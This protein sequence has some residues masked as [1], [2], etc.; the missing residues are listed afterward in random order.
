AAELAGYSEDGGR[1]IQQAVRI[2]LNGGLGTSMGLTGPKSLLPV[3]E[4][5]TF[6]EVIMRQAEVAGI[7]Q[8]LM[9][10][11][12]THTATLAALTEIP[13][14]TP[15]LTFI[16]NK[17]PKILQENL[18]PADWPEAPELEWNPPGHGDIYTAIQTSG[19][20]DRLLEGG[21]RYALICN[22]DN[23][24][25]TVDLPLLGF[26]AA[27]DIPFVMEVAR[28]T[29]ADAKGGH[30]AV[31][32]DGG[33]ILRESA[34][35]PADSD[36]GDIGRYA[37]FNT[38]NLWVNLPYLKTLIQQ[39]GTIPLPLILNP[40]T[41]DPRDPASPAV[42][43]LESAMGAATGLFEGARA[44]LVPRTRFFPV[45]KCND[46]LILRSDCFT[47]NNRFQL[48]ANPHQNHGGPL[49]SL[50]PAFYRR[51]DQFEARFP[52]GV[53]SLLECEQLTIRGDIRF[54]SPVT[55]KGKVGL[56]N[57]DS[58]QKTIEAGSVI[59]EDLIL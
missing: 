8:V 36:G 49:V 59:S 14:E 6:L 28:R 23:L 29:P 25:A 41:L 34:Q 20:L 40:K 39:H 47:L 24:G 55:I 43:Q 4:G 30:L 12:N 17:F 31:R 58:T 21:Y 44:V 48:E 5:L 42:F 57:P 53:P 7:R 32:P 3:R 52:A 9:N 13:H 27:N 51:I 26:M 2:T 15:P 45:K 50:D 33:L 54:E 35:F 37:Y 38:N 19:I 10:S 22:S 11:F 1:A 56:T 46:L 18:K 16:Q